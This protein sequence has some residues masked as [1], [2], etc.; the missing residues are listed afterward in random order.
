MG[1]KKIIFLFVALLLPIIIFIFL[2]LFGENQFDVPLI[3]EGSVEP[4][5][6]CNYQYSSPYVV[7]D[8]L[9]QKVNLTEGNFA[10]VDFSATEH[11][12]IKQVVEG[13]NDD[14]IE[15]VESSETGYTEAEINTLKKCVL[16]I[17]SPV[18]IVV[19]DSKNQ[20]RG[21]YASNDRD[22]LDRLEAELKILL[23]KY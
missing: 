2:R 20:I 10:I 14:R 12:L 22:E 13:L 11:L 8:S 21:Y 15:L 5:A 19:I 23:K 16:L 3:Y 4:P 7:P 18:D 1:G 6:G 17:K 9:S